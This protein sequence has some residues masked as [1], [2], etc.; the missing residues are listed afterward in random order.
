MLF[1][2]TANEELTWTHWVAAAP[3][4][5][6][7]GHLSAATGLEPLAIAVAASVPT[8]VVRSLSSDDQRPRRIRAVDAQGLLALE[9]VTLKARGDALAEARPAH[10]ALADLG[11][12]CPTADELAQRL[13]L[14]RDVAAGL[15]DGWLDVCQRVTVW[16]CVALANAIMFQRTARY[17]RTCPAHDDTRSQPD[18]GLVRVARAA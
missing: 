6:W 13:N 2:I 5:A 7:L 18:R 15:I 10:Q 14:G 1:D 17:G 8:G 12:L 3:F 4:R 16:R 9:P 11:H